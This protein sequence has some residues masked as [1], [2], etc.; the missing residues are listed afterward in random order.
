MNFTVPIGTGMK[1][2]MTTMMISG[3][4]EELSLL[5]EIADLSFRD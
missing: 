1:M 3:E 2:T 5:L 4:S